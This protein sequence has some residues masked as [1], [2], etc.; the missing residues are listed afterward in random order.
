MGSRQGDDDPI[1]SLSS[2][3]LEET[4][5]PNE[6]ST[7]D[8]VEDAGP[9]ISP[10]ARYVG[11][12]LG[13][14]EDGR[15]IDKD[16]N[17]VYD[18]RKALDKA[19]VMNRARAIRKKG[20]GYMKVEPGDD[21][22]KASL[23]PLW[24]TSIDDLEGFG[25][26]VVLYFKTLT[27]MGCMMIV[28]LAI[29]SW[30]MGYFSSDKYSG[31][32]Q[33]KSDMM[34]MFPGDIVGSAFCP[35]ERQ[36]NFTL[37]NGQEANFHLCPF[38][39]NQAWLDL[40]TSIF[41]LLVILVIGKV[42]DEQAEEI[43]ESVQTSQD[44]SVEI[45]DPGD[46]DKDN[47]PK[48]WVKFFGQF[49]TVTAVALAKKNGKLMR[50]LCDR[51][52]LLRKVD[53]EGWAQPNDPDYVDEAIR[54]H[55]IA[56]KQYPLSEG[57]T[58]FADL[59]VGESV[60]VQLPPLGDEDMPEWKA[61]AQKAGLF[62]DVKFLVRKIGALNQKIV[63]EIAVL[64]GQIESKGHVDNAR[65][66]ITYNLE[67]QQ[68]KCINALSTGS[69]WAFLDLPKPWF[70]RRALEYF[71]IMEEAPLGDHFHGN[72]LKVTLAPEPTDI[73][74][75]NLDVEPIEVFL[76]SMFFTLIGCGLIAVM[77]AL[78]KSISDAEP[79]LAGFFISVCN[80]LLPSIMKL[81]NSF[82]R[83]PTN[84]ASQASLLF[85]LVAARWT[86]SAMVVYVI[87]PWTETID[88]ERVKG[89]M[90]ILIAD[91]I[92]TPII[93]LANIG[94]NINRYILAPMAHTQQQL[95]DLLKGAPWFLAERYSDMTKTIY[96][97]LFYSA[98]LPSGYLVTA[99]ALFI[100]YW[101]DKFCL[102]RYWQVPPKL[103]ASITATTR[104]H[105]A[106]VII[107]HCII[108]LHYYAGWPFDNVV[109]R[110]AEGDLRHDRACIDDPS[111]TTSKV[112]TN[113]WQDGLIIIFHPRNF[114]SEE[115]QNV[116]ASY[117]V[118]T[119][120]AVII[121]SLVYF[122]QNVF[123]FLYSVFVGVLP[124]TTD[125]AVRPKSKKDSNGIYFV[126]EEEL[127]DTPTITVGGEERHLIEART[128]ELEAYVPQISHSGLEV[129]QLAIYH[130]DMIDRKPAEEWSTSG[131]HYDMERSWF[132]AEMMS[133][134]ENA[135]F[136]V[137][138]YE[139]N[140]YMDPILDR[141][142][143]EDRIKMFSSFHVISGNDVDSVV[144]VEAG[145]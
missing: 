64:Q 127:K 80:G 23:F 70:I 22:P 126:K 91:A 115:Q 62:H 112:N 66:F 125:P 49:G 145:L 96:I 110:N 18:F 59:G 1:A 72:V 6:T 107:I 53:L 93:R 102:L 82:E 104:S 5:D 16:G 44:Y 25:L 43:D 124:D 47:D 128:I 99:A 137:F 114:M 103:D 20:G 108:S 105:M 140:I 141:V 28:C 42:Q 63:D 67:T 14:G 61:V 4:I 78:I 119:L 118:F 38:N 101:V 29:N 36:F 79:T 87:T 134:N 65:V 60:R 8:L 89:I 15:K 55:I 46:T 121:V 12:K 136:G 143:E 129:P 19:D 109:C 75:E 21:N 9:S 31:G 81:L 135:K 69:L 39:D 130:Q 51:R 90:A 27:I 100:N 88:G 71:N 50:L 133:W 33:Q 57:E 17:E 113:L 139:N 116:V 34:A 120:I 24:H 54:E 26:G 37:T 131:S 95:E 7:A 132:P 117:Q 41:L 48:E 32:Y 85:K 84:T 56:G 98:I 45:E 83:H 122:G 68:R 138:F 52:A 76:E 111:Y 2:I 97:C 13:M 58:H 123:G 144:G 142:R 10:L 35:S 30:T 92:T 74:W 40:G 86:V 77:S 11:S 94:P 3:N 106:M 73:R